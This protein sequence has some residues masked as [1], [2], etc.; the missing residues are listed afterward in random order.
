MTQE[1]VS[2]EKA[3]QLEFKDKYL[4]LDYT[5]EINFIEKAL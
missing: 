1:D 5:D 2:K 4:F 3:K